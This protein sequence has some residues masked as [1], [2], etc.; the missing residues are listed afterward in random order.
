MLPLFAQALI[1]Q[2]RVVGFQAQH[3]LGPYPTAR[4]AVGGIHHHGLL[5]AVAFPGVSA[6][7]C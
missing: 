4:S 6:R 5:G 3:T 7:F 1:A 2:E